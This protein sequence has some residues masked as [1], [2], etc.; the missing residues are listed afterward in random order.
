MPELDSFFL[1]TV[2]ATEPQFT[3]EKK[4]TPTFFK[5][6]HMSSISC[7][8]RIHHSTDAI[9]KYVLDAGFMCANL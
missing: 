5:T 2:W 3:G 1:E 9:F 7:V 6:P 8:Y 4:I